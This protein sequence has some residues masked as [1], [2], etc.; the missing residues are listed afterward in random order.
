M[1]FLHFTNKL[2]QTTEKKIDFNLLPFNLSANGSFVSIAN[3]FQS[4]SPG[5]NFKGKISLA[6]VIS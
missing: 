3:I 4:V 2:I 5:T 1:M 6:N